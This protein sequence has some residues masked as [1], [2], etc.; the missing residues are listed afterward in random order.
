M[1]DEYQ[2][3]PKDLMGAYYDACQR[4]REEE[5]GAD[6]PIP[7][8]Q[9]RLYEKENVNFYRVYGLFTEDTTIVKALAQLFLISEK[10]YELMR[11]GDRDE[12]ELR[13]WSR[14]DGAAVLWVATVVSSIPGGAAKVITGLV[15]DLETHPYTKD[16]KTVAAFVTGPKGY[17]F[18]EAC[19]MKQRPE[20]YHDDLPFFEMPF[21]VSALARAGDILSRAWNIDAAREK[22]QKFKEERGGIV[23]LRDG[24][25]KS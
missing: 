14:E 7:L 23:T 13:P 16:I 8:E 19:G 18:A 5:F 22:L 12:R 1:S 10:E 25:F 21:E 11:K 24:S 9:T 15:D 2:V 3:L 6:V 4:F 20:K 17:L